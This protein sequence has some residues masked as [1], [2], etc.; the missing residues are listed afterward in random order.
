MSSLVN[1][2]GLRAMAGKEWCENLKWAALALVGLGVA[3]A[4]AV[5]RALPGNGLDSMTEGMFDTVWTNITATLTF[6]APLAGLLLGLLQILPE[7]RRDLW[8]FLVH[9]PASRA[10]LFWGKALA[11]LGLYALA[12]GLPLLAVALWARTPGHLAGPFDPRLTLG[13]V[14]AIL[15]GVVFYFAGMLTALR[16]ARWWGSRAL[17]IA[18]ALG[19]AALTLLGTVEEFRQAALI[20]LACA[21]V[22]GLAARGA[23]LTTGV[24][25]AQ[26]RSSRA[27][28]G[29][30]FYTGILGVL[31]ALF[32]V[33]LSIQQTLS[34]P[35][36]P[37]SYTQYQ[38]T[39]AGQIVRVTT[40]EHGAISDVVALAVGPVRLLPGEDQFTDN[41]TLMPTVLISPWE[42]V[43]TAAAFNTPGHFV[44][45]LS[46]PGGEG[47]ELWYYVPGVGQFFG[48]SVR[49]RQLI[50]ALGPQGFSPDASQVGRV[51][52]PLR[53]SANSA[54]GLTLL[55]SGHG[56]FL[57]DPE[58]R[59]VRP[60]PVGAVGRSVANVISLQT[61]FYY[62][63]MTS[64]LRP[65]VSHF[66]VASGDRFAVL[67]ELGRL[68]FTV[69]RA[70]D[71]Q[72]YPSVDA[73]MTPDGTRLFFWYHA[74]WSSQADVISE[75][76]ARGVLRRRA[77]LPPLT[78]LNRSVPTPR[79]IIGLYGLLVP[80]VV[81]ASV[82]GWAAVAH[83]TENPP[84][85]ALWADMRRPFGP[86]W[87]E[88]L[89]PSA[90]CGL[91]AAGLAWKIGRR[92]ADS[93]AGRW[94]WAVG[95]FWLGVPGLLL[96]L[97][98]RAWPAREPCPNCRR[99][100]VVTRERCEHC[101]APFLPPTPDGTEIFED[102][103]AD[104]LTLARP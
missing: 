5:G 46:L 94:A 60:L 76:D 92:C 99:P 101:G 26:S 37:V 73:A 66:I 61:P 6:G 67:T 39:R 53:D 62:P 77:V 91:I 58:T 79:P 72:S 40:D 103:G 89:L 65:T 8:A 28:L 34:P 70:E 97:S 71:R 42:P 68:C 87:T 4:F 59:D 84:A 45:S 23:F 3:L 30:V 29:L 74:R 75:Y 78:A 31:V 38:I 85:Q 82:L 41:D 32:F 10:T 36:S 93:P 27:A 69:P 15:V 86:L 9:R 44:L 88:F 25:E 24:Y 20:A 7:L 102:E 55:S 95:V 96:L 35:W 52:G 1:M 16:P 63:G 49:T 104:A 21:A 22:F 51:P 83:T 13:G 100:R 80:P 57:A 98:L 64:D 90:L 47:K 33:G 12:T 50:G 17:P 14:A 18:A 19:I 11:G 48:Y 43:R 2:A 54:N 56:L 81:D